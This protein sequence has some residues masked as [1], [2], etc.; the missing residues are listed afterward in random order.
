MA[1]EVAAAAGTTEGSRSGEVRNGLSVISLF[2]SLILTV[3][4]LLLLPLLLLLLLLLLQPVLALRHYLFF[5][6]LDLP[7]SLDHFV[8]EAVVVN[9]N[10]LLNAPLLILSFLPVHLHIHLSFL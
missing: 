7:V 3:Y 8:H 9:L 5:F 1:V 4:L 10:I 6:R 2:L